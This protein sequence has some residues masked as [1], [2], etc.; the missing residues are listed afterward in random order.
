MLQ[1]AQ[2]SSASLL[3]TSHTTGATAGAVLAEGL[4]TVAEGLVKGL[5][6]VSLR[7]PPAASPRSDL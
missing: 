2:A 5:N 4:V 3:H 6:I 7:A 1:R